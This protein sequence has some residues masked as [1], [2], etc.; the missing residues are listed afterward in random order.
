[1]NAV[2]IAPGLDGGQVRSLWNRRHWPCEIPQESDN[3]GERPNWESN[4]R[5]CATVPAARQFAA[6]V[7]QWTT[8]HESVD[9]RA[10][11][12]ASG[13]PGNVVVEIDNSTLEAR[14]PL[15]KLADLLG[16]AKQSVINRRIPK[17]SVNRESSMSLK[18]TKACLEVQRGRP[19]I[20]ES[21]PAPDLAAL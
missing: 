15:G 5:N 8:A 16:A 20:S 14:R 4:L 13:R 11:S 1:V 18:L 7:A 2:V 12:P 21:S 19:V 17:S 9:K 6:L 10:R 3:A